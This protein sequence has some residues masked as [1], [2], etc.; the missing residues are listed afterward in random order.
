[1]KQ[2]SESSA[3]KK[4]YESPKLLVYGDL[5]E[6]TQKGKS[7]RLDGGKTDDRRRTGA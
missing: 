5:I 3:K 1:M 6:M 2:P 4:P 7:G